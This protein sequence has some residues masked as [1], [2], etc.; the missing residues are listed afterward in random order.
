MK[1][2]FGVV[3]LF[4][5]LT[6]QFALAQD[7]VLSD[8]HLF[9]TFLK[10][11]PI[12][13]TPYG[14]AGLGF[15]DY[16]GGSSYFI[17]VQ[18]GYPINPKI[19][20]DA[21]WQFLNYLSNGNSQ[22]GISDLTVAGRYLLL[23]ENPLIS[24][25]AFLTLPIGSEDVGQGNFDFGIFGSLRYPLQNKMVISGTLG[26][27]SLEFRDDRETSL[28]FGGG[29]IY[30]ASEQLHVL[31]ELNIQTQIDYALLSGGVDYKLEMGSKIRGM[32]GFGLDDGAPDITI[33]GSFLHFF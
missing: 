3:I 29:L 1:V 25:G 23:E 22:S 31:G 2:V 26:L 28:L 24:G 19:E 13:F 27:E 12:S 33:M 4:F 16:D 17:G 20:V 15:G 9:Q 7:A 21:N 32:L 5:T 8:V 6:F 14:E 10:D 11:A 18:G 30:P